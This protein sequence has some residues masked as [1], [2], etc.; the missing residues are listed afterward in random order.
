MILSKLFLVS[1]TKKLDQLKQSTIGERQAFPAGMADSVMPVSHFSFG[2][3]A[4]KSLFT[5]FGREG[6]ISP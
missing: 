3:S 1:V 4:W 2:F 5:T 6:E